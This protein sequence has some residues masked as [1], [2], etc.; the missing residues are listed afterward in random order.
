VEQPRFLI[1]RKQFPA[2][3][4]PI[5]SRI[6]Y[7]DVIPRRVVDEMRAYGHRLEPIGLKGELVMGYASV[8]VRDPKTGTVRGGAD[9]RRSHVAGA[10]EK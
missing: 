4:P 10:V 3:Q 5:P 1:G 6:L 9:P 2:R 8:A 7:E